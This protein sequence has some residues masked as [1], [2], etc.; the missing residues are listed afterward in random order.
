MGNNR[1]KKGDIPW[2]KNPIK[3]ICLNCEKNFYISR[4]RNNDGRGKFDN[5]KCKKEYKYKL[6]SK[7]RMDE[8]LAEL[9]GIMIGDGCI[10]KVY[11]R[12]NYRI[13][14]SGNK[15]EDKDYMEKYLPEL[16]FRCLN[17]RP[18]PYLAK[19]GAY[20]LQF[21]SEPFRIFLHSIGIISPKSKIAS[22]PFIIKNNDNYLRRCIRGIADTDFT[23]IFTKRKKGGINY[24]PRICAQFA[25]FRLVQDLEESLKG[26]G[27]TLNTKYNYTRND[28]RGFTNIINYINLDGP[29]NLKRW[30]DLI[31]FSNQRINTRYLV[32][33]KYGYLKPKSTIVERIKLL[34]ELGR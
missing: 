9:I 32:W 5:F 14:I 3:K 26:M 12:D 15:V 30:L 33:R 13:Q 2:N 27:F 18:K 28:S 10:N 16:V 6:A 24:Y 19:N 11:N 25:S 17:I 7:F 8:D 20:V 29:H 34:G 21:Q 4:S 1:F 23:L 22:I 31:G